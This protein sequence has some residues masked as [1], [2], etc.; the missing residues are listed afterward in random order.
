[1]EHGQGL[2]T[3]DQKSAVLTDE[4]EKRCHATSTVICHVNHDTRSV[5]AAKT[6]FPIRTRA[7]SGGA[8]R[9]SSRKPVPA[10][11][12]FAAKL[13]PL[14]RLTIKPAIP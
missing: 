11:Q 8:L 5:A 10:I 3:S 2:A 1:M 13:N 4:L 14:S 9:I 6:N 7:E 12:R